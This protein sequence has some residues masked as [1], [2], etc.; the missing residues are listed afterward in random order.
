VRQGCD[1]YVDIRTLLDIAVLVR[2]ARLSLLAVHPLM[3]E[4]RLVRLVNS[5]SSLMLFTAV[6]SR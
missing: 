4:Q 3:S 5:L 6:E 2:L 1:Q